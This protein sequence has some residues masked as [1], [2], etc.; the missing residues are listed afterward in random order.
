VGVV[1]TSNNT[2]K[3]EILLGQ[4]AFPTGIAVSPDNTKLVVVDAGRTLLATYDINSFQQ[5][6]SVSVGVNPIALGNFV[7][8]QAPSSGADSP[9]P[10]SGIWFNPNESGWGIN[11]TQRGSNIF[12]AWYTYDAAGNP[13]WY[14]AP[15]CSMPAQNSC[16]G[17]L[18]QVT[19]P[20]FFGVQFDPSK[21]NVT[22]AG[23]TSIA[24]SSNDT[25]TFTYNVGGITRTVAIQREPISTGP[26]PQINFTDLWFNPDEPGWG[27]ALTQQASTI[28]AAWYV[29]DDSGNPVWYVVPNCPVDSSGTRCGGAVYRTTGPPL[30]SSFDP[31]QVQVFPAGNMIFN[32][33]DPNSGT[34]SYLFDNLFVTKRIVREVF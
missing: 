25:G 29:Y 18:Y 16:S 28:F 23:S 32:F 6:A 17:T 12:A 7:G 21:R 4:F 14:V 22:A 24:F 5:L 33:S 27:I 34:L 20:Q 1:D 26:P 9:G 11:F 19:G 8:P 3:F 30:G 2:M 10:L 15:N 31:S 13:K